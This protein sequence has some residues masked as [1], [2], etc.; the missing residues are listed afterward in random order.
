M[1]AWQ[2]LQ[3]KMLHS[4]SKVNLLI[5]I[6]IIV[7]L[8]INVP[9]TLAQFLFRTG[10]IGYYS[11]EYLQLPSNLSVLLKHFWTPVTYMFMH[12]GWLHI[13]FNMLWLYW[14]GQIFEEY[15]GKN[16]TVGLYLMGGLCG[17]FFFLL[18]YNTLPI[19]A[20]QDTSLVG[21]SAGVMAIIIA[22]ATLLPDYSLSLFLIGPVKLK[23]IAL[24]FVL[25]DFLGIIGP[26][27]GGEIA[28]LGGALIG[29]VYIKQLQKGNDW[30][31]RISGIFR[32][33][34]KLKV[35]SKNSYGKSAG[36]PRQE[37]IDL[38]LDKI[39]QSGYDSLSKQEKEVLFRASSNEG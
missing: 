17:A 22:T 29:F 39:S 4:G 8:L 20:H 18:C 1:T 7:F 30:V 36:K 23:W 3:Y 27:S 37:E 5:G 6:N 25:I 10:V 19:F 34:P 28:H 13:L 14:F 38:I 24:F 2:N 11:N 12:A 26:N 33:K 15:L 35:V 31:A 16:R 9:D 21:A 32:A